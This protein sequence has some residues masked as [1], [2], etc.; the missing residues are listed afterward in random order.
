MHL[1]G[2]SWPKKLYSSLRR[3]PIK[4]NRLEN[5]SKEEFLRAQRN[6][7]SNSQDLQ[8]LTTRLKAAKNMEL[9]TAKEA[10]LAQQEAQK[11]RGAYGQ[12]RIRGG[13]QP[14]AK[15]QP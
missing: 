4:P 9:E 10:L 6:G 13:L 12:R 3:E 1:G 8:H 7:N 14:Q 15:A 5:R 11:S 2:L